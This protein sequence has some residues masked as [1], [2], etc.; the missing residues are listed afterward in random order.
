MEEARHSVE[1]KVAQPQVTIASLGNKGFKP[2]E[3]DMPM[4]M[5]CP[6][7]LGLASRIC[8]SQQHKKKRKS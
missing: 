4:Q 6:N 3:A 5:V 7:A 8:Q 2:Q 1:Q